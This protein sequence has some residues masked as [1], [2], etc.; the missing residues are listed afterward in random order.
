MKSKLLNDDFVE[1]TELVEISDLIEY[2]LDNF[3]IDKRSKL[4]KIW[5]QNLIN[6]M[7]LYNK[8][9]GSK[10]YNINYDGFNVNQQ[11]L[12]L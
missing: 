5:R 6:L 7:L 9:A 4:F 8:K 1:P 10:I 2:E 3:D 11:L 12:C